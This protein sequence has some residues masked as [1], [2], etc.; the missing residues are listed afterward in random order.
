MSLGHFPVAYPKDSN[1]QLLLCKHFQSWSL[2][3]PLHTVKLNI[4]NRHMLQW[5]KIIL[6]KPWCKSNPKFVTSFCQP[7]APCLGPQCQEQNP[8]KSKNKLLAY[9]HLNPWCF[10]IHICLRP[11]IL[12]QGTKLPHRPW[13]SHRSKW[14]QAFPSSRFFLWHV[15]SSQM[16]CSCKK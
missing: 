13:Q 4:P 5:L 15:V 9:Q 8:C 11:G 16:L 1:S 10:H 2:Q 7:G 3:R 12:L 14:S 6:S